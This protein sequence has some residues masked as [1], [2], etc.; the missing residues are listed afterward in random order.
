MLSLLITGVGI[1]AVAPDRSARQASLPVLA[2][3]AMLLSVRTRYW[4]TLPM[5]TGTRDEYA[6]LSF[7]SAH[8][9]TGAPFI[10]FSAAT[11]PLLPPGVTRSIGPSRSGD[12][13]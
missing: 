5:S 4:G 3:P 10:L 6:A 12:S 13:E 2:I 9:H 8:C 11:V 1:T 7:S